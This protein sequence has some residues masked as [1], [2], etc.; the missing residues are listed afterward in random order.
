MKKIIFPLVLL[1]TYQM[2]I[3]QDPYSQVLQQIEANSTRLI[4][5]RQQMEAQQ[6]NNP[7]G[8]Y[9]TNPE[10]EFNHLWGRPAALG[11][12]TTFYLKQSFDFP[13]AYAHRKKIA[14]LENTN[15]Q[16]NYKAERIELLLQAKELCIRLTY[17]NALVQQYS[18]RLKNAQQVASLYQKRS[19]AGDAN[20]LETNKAELNLVTVQNQHAEAEAEQNRLLSELKSLNGGVGID[21]HTNRFAPL[22]NL[23]QFEEWYTQAEQKSP[24]LQYLRTK[25]E[26]NQKYVQLNKA[27]GLPKF[28]TGYTMEKVLGQSLNGISLG[29]TIP[30][31]ENKNKV[32]QAKLELKAAQSIAEDTGI[33]FYHQ[34]YSLYQRAISLHTSLSRYRTTLTQQNTENLLHKA[35]NGGA[36]SLLNYL[37]ELQYYY[38]AT[39]K[40]LQTEQE[41]AL[42]LAQL[43]ALEL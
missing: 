10:M 6:L 22:T 14:K 4:A 16:L 21:F 23:P 17:S 40:L 24:A 8:L 37:L 27:M 1:F 9:L 36:I 30:L 38:E 18:L 29:M 28:T 19:Q 26:V 2:L 41:L 33:Q 7:E 32:K 25:V 39:D 15:A 11:N 42:T 35:L 34:L 3:A 12:L 43:S 13:S 5:L 20:I 31:W